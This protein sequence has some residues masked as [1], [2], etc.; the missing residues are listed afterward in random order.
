MDQEHGQERE[1]NK[2]HVEGTMDTGEY[3]TFDVPTPNRCAEIRALL[4]FFDPIP[5]RSSCT[6]GCIGCG[7]FVDINLLQPF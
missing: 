1:G 5:I 6:D 2:I 4:G 7:F 3:L